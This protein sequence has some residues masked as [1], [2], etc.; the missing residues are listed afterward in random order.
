MSL[1]DTLDSILMQSFKDYEIIFIDG[2]SSDNTLPIVSDF[3][4]LNN[5]VRIKLLS[6][7]DQGIYDAMNKGIRLA[8]GKWLYFMGGDDRFY[9]SDVL[10]G[11]YEELN[12]ENVDLIYGNV[13]GISSKTKYAYD[14]ISKVLSTG[15]HHQSVFYKMSLFD[16]LGKYDLKFKTAADY[17]FTLKVFLNE[18]YKTKYVNMDI[19]IYGEAGFSSQNF[20]YLFYSYHYKFLAVNDGIRKIETPQKCLEV[21]IYCCLYLA[22]EK[23]NILFAWKNLLFYITGKNTYSILLRTKTA[24]RM[25]MWNVIPLKR[26]N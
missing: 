5:N 21:S 10:N 4:N 6:A 8:S 12:K 23:K 25:M 7:P 14:T 1:K 9:S 22:K 17:H 15:I 24:A 16:D 19:A 18:A 3:E 13:Y 26:I 20:D 2:G 11:I